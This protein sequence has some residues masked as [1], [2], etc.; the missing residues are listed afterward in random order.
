MQDKGSDNANNSFFRENIDPHVKNL[1]KHFTESAFTIEAPESIND[2]P[3]YETTLYLAT[4]KNL[5]MDCGSFTAY[6]FQDIIHK[7]YIIA[8]AFGDIFNEKSFYTRIHS[9]CVTSETLQACDCDCSE[10]LQKSLEIIVKNKVGIFFYL[11]Q[12]GR[13][14]GY[15]AKARDRMLVQA[16]NDEISTF[17]AYQL[18]GLRKDYRQYRNIRPICKMLNIDPEFILLTNN[19]QKIHDLRHLG[20]KIKRT[21]TLESQPSPYNLA[22]LRSK[23]EA[24]HLLKEPRLAHLARVRPP[25]PVIPFKP[26]TFDEEK[27]YILTASYFL[28]IRP[29][30]D[31]IIL[32]SSKFYDYFND[33]LINELNKSNN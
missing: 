29:V 11:M 17:E 2:K 26:H 30:D 7:G 18:L 16:T 10:Q 21:E 19:P 23:M 25:K 22:Y 14:V 1:L 27:R 9:S 28:P 24:G 8:L 3:I 13:G 31:E 4:C 20:I 33:T 5:E 15:I 32:S 12:E 6:I